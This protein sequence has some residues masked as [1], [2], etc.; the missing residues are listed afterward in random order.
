ME[1]TVSSNISHSGIVDSISGEMVKVRIVQ[2]SSCSSC[3]V[4]SYCSS[5]ESKEKFIDVKCN[6][7]ARYKIGQKVI[8][9]TDTSNGAKAVILAFVM[10][11][12][13]LLAAIVACLHVGMTEGYAALIGIAVLVPYY[14][15]IYFLNDTL[16]KELTF[17]IAPDK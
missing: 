11:A 16:R 6:N 17:T 5:S 3:K 8:V 2:S 9:S 12:V 10:P 14:L 15:A 4:A 7:P 1:H 13:L